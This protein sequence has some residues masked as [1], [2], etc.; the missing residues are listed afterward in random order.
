VRGQLNFYI[1]LYFPSKSLVKTDEIWMKSWILHV[2][3]LGSVL[4]FNYYLFKR[5]DILV[6]RK[7]NSAGLLFL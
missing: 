1:F 4:N 2:F 3:Y 6:G 7:Q 5:R